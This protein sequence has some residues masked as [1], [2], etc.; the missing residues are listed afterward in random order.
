TSGLVLMSVLLLLA[1][2]RLQQLSPSVRQEFQ[3]RSTYNTQSVKRLQAVR[4]V[5]YD[6]DGVPLA[7]NRL[8]YEIGVSPNLVSDPARVAQQL[9]VILNLDEFSILQRI[10]NTNSQWELIARGVSAE[11]GQAVADEDLLGVVI[12]PMLSRAYPQGT[13]GSQLIGFIFGDNDNTRGAMGVEA[14][15]NEQLA[16]RSLERTVSTVPIDTPVDVDSQGQRGMDIVLTIDRDIQYWVETE[17]Q[18]AIEQENASG[19]TI[20]VMNPRNGEILAMATYP[21]FDPNNFGAVEDSSLL[22][23][24]S[25]SEVYE[26]GSVMKVM[27]VAA[28]LDVGA[29]TP[30]WTYNDTGSIT[31]GSV[32]TQNWDRNAYGVVDTTGLLVNSLNVGAATVATTMGPEAFYSGL[33]RF[34]IGRQT[35]ID[36]EGEEGGIMRVPGDTGWSESDLAANSYG[37]ALS[38]TPLQMITAFSA[39]ANDGLMYQPHLARQYV[40]GDEIEFVNPTVLG[41]AISAETASIMTDMLVQVIV[42]GDSAAAIP[43]YTIAGKTGTAEFPSPLGYEEGSNSTIASFIGFFPADDPQVVV[44]V[45][46]DRPNGYWGSQTA[47]PVF[48][49]VAQRLILLLG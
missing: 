11:V 25:I 38:V 31:V 48:R 18:R 26:P 21:T 24:P 29:I 40:N 34:G 35:G 12:N 4:G 32:T 46:L 45:K 43:G 37:Q 10:S 41:R 27:T 36:L 22:D 47:A 6:R 16:G 28:A 42:Q 1:M 14:S 9:G 2:A 33:R 15:Y 7:F 8:Q 49:T 20:I 23:T 39:I 19:G 5:I 17:L 44:L 13:L 30:E 3:I